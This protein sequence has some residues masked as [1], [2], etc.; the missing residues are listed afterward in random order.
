[1]C[2]RDSSKGRVLYI[3][4]ENE[5]GEG[6]GNFGFKANDGVT[7]SDEATVTVNV[8]EV[9]DRISVASQTI[10]ATEDIHYSIT[11]SATDAQERDLTYFIS[12]IPIN[13]WLFQTSD[14]SAVGDTITIPT[15]VTNDSGKVVYLSDLNGNGD[16]YGNFNFRASAGESISS[17]AT[18]TIDVLSVN[19]APVVD[20]LSFN[21][22][23]NIP[24]GTQ[25]DTL[26]AF[27][28]DSDQ[29]LMRDWAIINGDSIG[30]FSLNDTTGIL[31]TNAILNFEDTPVY[32]ISVTVTD[33]IDT[34]PAQKMLIQLSD[35][36]EGVL[37]DKEG[38]IVT[39]EYGESDTFTVVLQSLPFDTVTV[40]LSLSDS[41][42]A[43]LSLDS[44][45]FPPELWSTPQIV[46]ITGI[47]DSINDPNISYSIILDSTLSSDPNYNGLDVPDLSATNMAR[48]V[49]GPTVEIVATPSIVNAGSSFKVTASVTD[50]NAVSEALLYFALGGNANFDELI[51]GLSEDDQYQVTIPSIAITYRGISYY[52]SASDTIGN[53]SKSEIFSTNVMF[54]EGAL[55]SDMEAS[56]LEDSLPRNKWRMISIPAKLDDDQVKTVLGEALG[57]KTSETWAVKQWDGDKWIDPLNL[58]EGEGYWLI[59]DVDAS[60]SFETGSGISHDQSGYTFIFQPGWNMIG[61]PYPFETSFELNQSFFRGPITYGWSIEGWSEE[62]TLRPWGGY[63]VYNR[64][65]SPETITLK[66][67]Q[68]SP[69]LARE[70]EIQPHGWKLNLSAYGNTYVDPGNAIG[71][72][73][74]SL[75]GL[76]YRDNPEPPYLG[77]HVSLVMTRTEWNEN[78][79]NFTS[80]IRSLEEENGLWNIEMRVKE[81]TGPVSL[82]LT[83]EGI[84][85]VE[86]DIVLL[87]LLTREIHDVNETPSITFEQPWDKLS[88]YP[89]KVIAGT[90]EYVSSTTQEI[91][92]Q[93]PETFALHQNYPNPFNP[94]TTIGF[95]VPI[96]SQVSLKI[97]NLMGQEIKTLTNQWLPTGSHRL[98][99][100][101]KNRQG[102]PVS[103]GVYIYRLQSQDF[104]KTRKMVLLK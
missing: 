74:G 76:D 44:L 41:T 65:D 52:I 7:D 18:V 88:V 32:T 104:Q 97:Y 48:D 9:D 47:E 59:H 5:G 56:V 49:Y 72:L 10:S 96:P 68:I 25:L 53:N 82:S 78:I 64:G 63:A 38:G 77:G 34:S 51:M 36:E 27:D 54:A 20:S 31:S 23:E 92:S 6:H 16:G 71:R 24:V 84:F 1:M 80:D 19:D 75:E 70:K 39:S 21:I 13:G 79:S 61:N 37:I 94:T 4:A 100:N 22:A 87:D 2:I 8:I 101:G 3:S 29:S 103:A 12:S 73:S 58:L 81:E 45:L 99:W 95:E 40:N 57:E 50:N 26:S 69:S 43:F 86:H 60:P 55:S 62:S 42:E 91:L 28:I 67:V 66:P 102:I 11:L 33:G 35:I 90:P 15:T 17:E 98:I 93:L 14:T 85:P 83:M 89:F 46:T 30:Q